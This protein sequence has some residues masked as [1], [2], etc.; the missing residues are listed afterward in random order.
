[1]KGLLQ[2]ERALWDAGLMRAD[3]GFRPIQETSQP[4][5]PRNV[6][7]E[8]VHQLAMARG[9]GRAAQDR[10]HAQP[11]AIGQCQDCN[12]CQLSMVPHTMRWG[13]VSADNCPTEHYRLSLDVELT[14]RQYLD[15]VIIES[16]VFSVNSYLRSAVS[17]INAQYA[18]RKC[19]TCKTLP[20]FLESYSPIEDHHLVRDVGLCGRCE[21]RNYMRRHTGYLYYVTYQGDGDSIPDDAWSPITYSMVNSMFL[22]VRCCPAQHRRP[23][24]D[25]MATDQEQHPSRHVHPSALSSDGD[26]VERTV[27]VSSDNVCIDG[28]TQ[29]YYRATKT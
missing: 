3:V 10:L 8:A 25:L 2:A 14:T 1:M 13:G 17:T 26:Q 4:S 6:N 28:D 29:H 22:C 24:L 16:D 19:R 20:W 21:N 5:P 23:T 18:C 7:E 27:P 11:N 12:V 15:R 9:Q